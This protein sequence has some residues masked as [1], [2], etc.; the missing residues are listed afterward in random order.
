MR[1]VAFLIAR[2]HPRE[3]REAIGARTTII[4]YS[5]RESVL[6][7]FECSLKDA[8]GILNTAT[9]YAVSLIVCSRE[10]FH[11]SACSHPFLNLNILLNRVEHSKIGA[12]TLHFAEHLAA[13]FYIRRTFL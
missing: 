8:H 10:V 7:V 1:M 2:L 9:P 12:P 4:R 5:C 11:L 13:L 3:E 6:D